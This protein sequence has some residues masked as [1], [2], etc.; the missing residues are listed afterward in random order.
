MSTNN[1]TFLWQ[2]LLCNTVALPLIWI[3]SNLSMCVFRP[4]VVQYKWRHLRTAERQGYLSKYFIPIFCSALLAVENEAVM[5]SRHEKNLVQLIGR[6]WKL[7][8][9]YSTCQSQNNYYAAVDLV[10]CF[11]LH[12]IH[13]YALWWRKN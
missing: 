8:N 11:I 10:T 3:F 5:N 4:D 6:K 12:Y 2:H 13:H 9:N 7:S 1:F